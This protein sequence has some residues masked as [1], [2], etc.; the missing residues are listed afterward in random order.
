MELAARQ[1]LCPFQA[2][3]SCKLR[4]RVAA[5]ASGLTAGT[6]LCCEVFQS[7]RVIAAEE[8]EMGELGGPVAHKDDFPTLPELV[9]DVVHVPQVDSRGRKCRVQRTYRAAKSRGAE[10]FGLSRRERRIHSHKTSGE[11]MCGSGFTPARAPGKLHQFAQATS[12]LRA[13]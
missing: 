11:D 10:F 6:A 7:T 8:A 1:A 2:G 9:P 4:A 3:D 12:R 13:L 5:A